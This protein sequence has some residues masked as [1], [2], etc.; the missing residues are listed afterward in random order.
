MVY[1]FATMER[2]AFSYFGGGINDSVLGG[3]YAIYVGLANGLRSD[4]SIQE[5]YKG[6]SGVFTFGGD[7]S[8]MDIGV[9]LEGIST[10]LGVIGSTSLSDT[11]L[12]TLS[13]YMGVG[14]SAISLPYIDVGFG[15]VT[16]TPSGKYRKY[17]TNNLPTMVI[18][19]INGNNTIYPE[20][21]QNISTLHAM[22]VY[23]MYELAPYYMYIYEEMLNEE[24]RF[25][26]E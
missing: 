21:V 12:K 9:P 20:G 6:E 18:D 19:M 7:L 17:G 3:G 10:G 2:S 24:N 22:R 13:L 11:K 1:D 8:L 5:H 16:Y 25:K 4:K 14:A 15:T 23:A 26:K